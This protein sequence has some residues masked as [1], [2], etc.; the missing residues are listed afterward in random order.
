MLL[1][2]EEKERG[3]RTMALRTVRTV[4]YR[5]KEPIYTTTT[6]SILQHSASLQHHLSSSSTA[7]CRSLPRGYYHISEFDP[8]DPHPTGLRPT[9]VPTWSRE[10]RPGKEGLSFRLPKPSSHPSQSQLACKRQPPPL[11]R[12]LF[13]A[14]HDLSSSVLSATGPAQ[15]CKWY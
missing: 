13:L 3:T 12:V 7:S 1:A 10:G 6:V 4:Q 14:T 15:C 2:S 11:P 5:R 9:K 8:F